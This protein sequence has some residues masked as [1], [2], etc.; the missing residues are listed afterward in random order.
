MF[1]AFR[2]KPGSHSLRDL[3]AKGQDSGAS[4]LGVNPAQ[5]PTSCVLGDSGQVA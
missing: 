5:P 2:S 1:L 3:G 4:S